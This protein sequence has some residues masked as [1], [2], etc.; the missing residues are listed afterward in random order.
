MLT[1]FYVMSLSSITRH[2]WINLLG[3]KFKKESMWILGNFLPKGKRSRGDDKVEL[4]TKNGVT[5]CLPVGDEEQQSQSIN[6]F[7]KMG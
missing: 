1:T 3:T 2:M 6:S 4:L 5:Y 7:K